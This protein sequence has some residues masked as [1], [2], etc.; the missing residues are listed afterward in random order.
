MRHTRARTCARSSPH[1][2]SPP[3]LQPCRALSPAAR[4]C[5]PP[6]QTM[7]SD[8]AVAGVSLAG[9]RSRVQ[10]T[11]ANVRVVKRGGEERGARGRG[12]RR[13]ASGDD[14][15]GRCRD[16]A[17]APHHASR[18][19]THPP[20][21]RSSAALTRGAACCARAA[22][23]APNSSLRLLPRSWRVSPRPSPR[24]GSRQLSRMRARC[25]ARKRVISDFFSAFALRH[26]Q[27]HAK[28]ASSRANTTELTVSLRKRDFSSFLRSHA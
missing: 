4:A 26:T 2:R 20:M 27:A 12:A 7:G 22:W 13:Q 11:N 3:V 18:R 28:W 19:L 21:P 25:R 15:P 9:W 17:A 23:A 16:A 5:A 24:Q 1:A 10:G 8:A 14:K 6:P